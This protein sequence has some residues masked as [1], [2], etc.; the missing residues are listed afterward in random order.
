MKRALR[1]VLAPRG[2][3][4]VSCLLVLLPMLVYLG[5]QIT[6]LL[7]DPQRIYLG[8][9]ALTELFTWHALHGELL[10]GARSH[11]G[12]QH[13]GPLPFYVMAP[14][15]G[16]SSCSPQGIFLA[17]LLVN[18]LALA[19]ILAALWRCGGQQS[20]VCFALVWTFYSWFLDVRSLG[21]TWAI[22]LA[23]VPFV[24]AVVF[25]AAVAAGRLNWLPAALFCFSFVVQTHLAYGPASA[26]VL[27]VSSLLGCL[28]AVRDRLGI[29]SSRCGRLAWLLPGSAV[30]LAVAWTPTL[31]GEMTLPASNLASI[32]KFLGQGGDHPSCQETLGGWMQ[33]IARF[34]LFCT[35]GARLPPP[36]DKVVW[37]HW[38]VGR[39]G[40]AALSQVLGLLLAYFIARRR[41]RDFLCALSAMLALLLAVSALSIRRIP[42]PVDNYLV[43]WMTSASLLMFVV[44]CAVCWDWAEQ[45]GWPH[46]SRLARVAGRGIVLTML[47][48]GCARSVLEIHDDFVP[49]EVAASA[50]DA[51]HRALCAAVGSL[52]LAACEVLEQ[53]R[54]SQFLVRFPEHDLWPS[55]AALVLHLAK[56][57]YQAHVEPAWG[58]MFGARHLATGDEELT[59]LLCTPQWH[60]RLGPQERFKLIAQS[61]ELLLFRS[62]GVETGHRLD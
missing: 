61:Q 27:L 41:G 2:L 28:P 46:D 44:L 3:A 48:F 17:V 50:E 37:H 15:Y 24:A 5:L 11:Y 42:G 12:F 58:P 35:T 52:S 31:I 7:D 53:E 19:G 47:V 32:V 1:L 36:T 26:A 23:H 34:P 21:S 56:A 4:A 16:L 10:E 59:F 45:R 9:I 8:D 55:A 49:S 25:S 60:E 6:L 18:L 14:W 54:P 38:Q 40:V 43:Y 39:D 62:P 20:V 30:V 22:F 29:R 13:A 57:E 33:V 51:P